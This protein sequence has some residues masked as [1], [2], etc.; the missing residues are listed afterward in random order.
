VQRLLPGRL[1][2]SY[3]N[4]WIGALQPHCDDSKTASE[5]SI[6]ARDLRVTLEDTVQWLAD[7]GHLSVKR[8]AE[9]DSMPS[10][11]SRIHPRRP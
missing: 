3:E 8:P 1:P 9:K 2:F 6:T 7:Q 10:C 4:I 5:L 11:L